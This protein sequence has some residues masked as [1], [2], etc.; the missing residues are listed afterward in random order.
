MSTAIIAEG[1]GEPV[2]GLTLYR[3]DL[4]LSQGEAARLS[5][6]SRRQ[7]ARLEG[8]TALTPAAVRLALIYVALRV[9][10][11]AGPVLTVHDGRE[12]A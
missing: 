2:N 4:G 8:E 7:L 1:T 5:G 9:L 11:G 6:V 10:V 3:E 12:G